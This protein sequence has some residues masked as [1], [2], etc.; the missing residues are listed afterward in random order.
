MAWLSEWSWIAAVGSGLTASLLVTLDERRT[1]L[2]ILA[3]QYVF[4]AWL[5]AQSLPVTIATV[6][7]V[8][9]FMACGALAV[10][11]RARR[12]S[13]PEH[14]RTP[15]P[16][17]HGFRWAA[18]LLVVAVAFGIGRGEWQLV[19]DLG[20]PNRLGT[21]LL[22]LLGLLQIGITEDPLRAG[23]GLL[24]AVSGFEVLY[25]ALEP[26]LAVTALLASVHLGI[27]IVVSYLLGAIPETPDVDPELQ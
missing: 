1:S 12:W 15:L 14:D 27:A 2:L 21:A 10:T 18:V 9:G 5:V 6:K 26:S 24:T 7:L 22:F 3:A 20:S 8:A 16:T 23:I 17:G 19:P 4:C 11:I 13:H 25:S